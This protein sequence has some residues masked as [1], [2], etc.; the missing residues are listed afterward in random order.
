[1]LLIVSPAHSSRILF[2]ETTS[3]S[4]FEGICGS[5]IGIVDG[6]TCARDFHIGKG[7]GISIFLVKDGKDE[8]F[9]MKVQTK[10]KKS[11]SESQAYDQ[12]KNQRY[13]AQKITEGIFEDVHVMV[14]E[15]ATR[16]SLEVVLQTS[17]YFSNIFKTLE[18]FDKLIQGI[19]NI[20]DQQL[21]HADINTR[22]VHVT[23][24]YEPMIVN[25]GSAVEMGSEGYFRGTPMYMSP[26]MV[27]AMNRKEP[28]QFT[29]ETDIFAAGVLLYFMKTHLF[30]FDDYQMHYNAMITSPVVFRE[31]DSTLF[32]NVIL[33]CLQLQPNISSAEKLHSYISKQVTEDNEMPLVNSY[34]YTM[35]DHKL[36]IFSD[37][38]I[39]GSHRKM[40]FVVIG[41]L[42]VVSA[43]L[44]C[45]C[46][47]FMFFVWSKT[48]N[49]VMSARPSEM[50][51]DKT[52]IDSV[53]VSKLGALQ[54]SSKNVKFDAPK[55]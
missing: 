28:L 34:V 30:P 55:I 4:T 3:S 17:D 26:E 13:I 9:A 14:L 42:V 15:Y 43:V 12:L 19:K 50:H 35:R 7:R 24:K 5:Y 53:N 23:E 16:K 20:H 11:K 32:M 38:S 41:S 44:F 45:F 1:M 22:N 2:E 27:L 46:Q 47:V 31:G 10:S 51:I 39:L 21:V 6:F 18:F 29:A 37:N 25:F 36:V 48:S 54:I 33:R 49:N 40:V 52:F 8:L